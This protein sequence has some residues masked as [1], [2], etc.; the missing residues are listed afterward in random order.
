MKNCVF[1]KIAKK[2]K[3]EIACIEPLNPVVPG[4]R[5]VFAAKHSMD[6]ADN[7]DLTAKVMKRAAEIPKAK[8]AN[9]MGHD[10]EW[11]LITSKGMNATQ[12]VFHLHVHLVPRRKGDGLKLPWTG[13]RKSRKIRK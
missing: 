2:M 8:A 1:C 9:L 11:N 4:H 7:P 3:V 5:I 13:Q 12:S 6:F 10:G